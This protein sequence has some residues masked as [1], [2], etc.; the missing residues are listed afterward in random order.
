[1]PG[2][3]V[4]GTCTV[5]MVA[6]HVTHTP[7]ALRIL[8]DGKI[9][10]GLIYDE[11]ALNNSRTTVVWLSPNEWYWGS[12]YGSVEFTFNFSDLVKARKIYWVEAQIGYKP[13]A[14]RFLITDQD[15]K[16]LPVQFYGM[17]IDGKARCDT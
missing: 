10:R 17:R 9:T 1:M 13:P 5:M 8:E 11:C 15:V 14:R 12:R 6:H 7:A 2:K 4:A 3:G 16:H